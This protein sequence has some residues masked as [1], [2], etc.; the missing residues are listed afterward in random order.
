[1]CPNNY[2]VFISLLI[3]FKFTPT[4][5]IIQIIVNGLYLIHEF[6]DCSII[7]NFIKLL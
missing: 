4:M 6:E 1:M 7:F 2:Y 3:M 5:V